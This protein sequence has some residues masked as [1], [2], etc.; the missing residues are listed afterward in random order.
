MKGVTRVALPDEK[1]ACLTA[2]ILW[3]KHHLKSN[4]I[5]RNIFFR[6]Y[7]IWEIFFYIFTEKRFLLPKKTCHYYFIFMQTIAN[8]IHHIRPKNN[9][10]HPK[11]KI[12]VYE[13]FEKFF[14]ITYKNKMPSPKMLAKVFC[15]FW[16]LRNRNLIVTAKVF[17]EVP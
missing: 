9:Q 10:D 8:S 5:I 14:K 13:F 6:K 3:I 1:A 2:C 16:H 15:K 17:I 12:R 7:G 11:N 4:G